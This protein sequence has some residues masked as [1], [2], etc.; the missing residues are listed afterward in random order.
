MSGSEFAFPLPV[1]PGHAFN[2]NDPSKPPGSFDNGEAGVR[3]SYLRNGWDVSAFFFHA[4]DQFP[5]LYR[6]VAPGGVYNFDPQ[7]QRAHLVGG[8]F[9]KEIADIVFKGEF[10]VNPRGH[11]A[12]FD[13]TDGDG[14]VAKPVIDY[15]LGAN[16]TFGKVDTG[17]Q[18]MQRVIAR[19]ADLMQDDTT[20]AHV[21]LWVKT[22]VLNGRVEPEFLLLTGIAEQDL[23]YRPKV[24]W[25]INDHWQWR[26]GA[27]IFQGKPS[28]LFGRFN[29][30]SRAYTELS[31]HF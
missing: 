28:G 26:T 31:Y 6:T 19:H 7:Y 22:S 9:S 1:P 5:V 4:W 27:D 30:H 3:L 18:F 24:T 16:H 2:I 12:T 8:S 10:V 21:S 25:K 11:F 13:P 17:V 23:L 15:L 29:H 14:I 20:D